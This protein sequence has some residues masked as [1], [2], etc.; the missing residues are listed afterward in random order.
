MGYDVLN[1]LVDEN[2]LFSYEYDEIGNRLLKDNTDYLYT[3]DNQ[4]TSVDKNDFSYDEAGNTTAEGKHGYQYND[5]GILSDYSWSKKVKASYIYNGFGQRIEK[6]I[7]NKSITFDYDPNGQLISEEIY[8][9]SVKKESREII[10]LANR[11]IAQ[12]VTKFSKKKS[13][14]EIFY[15]HVDHLNTPRLMTDDNQTIVWKWESDAFGLGKPDQDPDG[16]GNDTII[17]L[18]FPGQYY[19]KESELHYNYFRYY[20]PRIGRYITSDPIGIKGGMN[21]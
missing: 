2:S 3:P 14:S 5:Q 19:D 4:L 1:R 7:G 20:N 13:K 21:T 8:I 16:D 17:N 12:V 18:R 9:H 15:I 10:W 11:P 6:I